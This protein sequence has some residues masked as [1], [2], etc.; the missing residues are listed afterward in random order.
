MFF[1]RCERGCDSRMITALLAGSLGVWLKGKYQ[2]T[3]PGLNHTL[4]QNKFSAHF[5]K[6]NTLAVT[7]HNLRLCRSLLM[8]LCQ[9]DV[10]RGGDAGQSRHSGDTRATYKGWTGDGGGVRTCMSLNKGHVSHGRRR[11]WQ[12][13]DICCHLLCTN[14]AGKRGVL[15]FIL[16]SHQVSHLQMVAD[17]V[18]WA[19]IPSRR[20]ALFPLNR[21]ISEEIYV[22]LG[23]I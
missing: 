4:R 13:A 14:T 16:Q 11:G 5:S 9:R 2:I 15:A 3:A 17:P 22:N 6:I 21:Q 18:T 7:S 23:S 1:E 19:E 12:K 8:R 20:L 10:P